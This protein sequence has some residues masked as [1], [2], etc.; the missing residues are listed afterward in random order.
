MK[1]KI[2][3]MT[4]GVPH[5]AR[6]RAY[7][8]GAVITAG[9]CGVA[10]R[11]YALQVDE[12]DHY[13]ELAER[14]HQTDV[15]IPAPRGNV[16]DA[17][18]RPLAVSADADSIWANPREIHD[19]T[20]VADKLGKLVNMEPGALE[21]KL[22]VDKKF[23]WIARQV[24]PEVAVAV[25]N[26]K[27]P[28]IVVAKEPRRWYPGKTIGGPVIGRADIDSRGLEG[29]ELSM[30]DVL[31]GSRGNGQAVRDAHGRKMFA[32]GM[33]Q[34]E[35]GAT[36]QLSLDRSIQATADQAIADAVISHKAKSG[37]VVVVEVATGRVLA[38]SSY[39]TYDPNSN[40]QHNAARNRPVT[41]AFESGSV[42]KVFTVAA[43]IDDGLVGAQTELDVGGGSFVVGPKRITDVHPYKY[44]TVSDIIKHSSNVGA[45]KIGLRLGRDK[46][47]S[48]FKQ[49][50][51]GAKSGIELPGEQVGMMRNGAK[52]RDIELATMSYGYG[53]TVTP[54]QVAAGLAALGNGGVYN[55]PRIIDKV[56]D[57]DGTVLYRPLGESK[58]MVK[59]QT[60]ATMQKILGTVFEGGKDGG[61]AKDVIVPGFKCGGKTGTAYKYDPET[62]HYATDRYL[63]SFAGLAP[64]DNPK[65]AIVVMVDE[66]SGG[67]HYGGDVAGPV[68][69]TVASE[70]LRYLGVPGT[71]P[72]CPP[73][74]PGYN[75]YLDTSVK[76]CL[77]STPPP[78]AP[79]PAPAPA[80]APE[81]APVIDDDPSAVPAPEPGSIAI[82]DFAG[83]GVQRA[84]DLARESHL[85]VDVKGTGRV[86]S[87]D[88][89][90]G[91][92]ATP[93]RI[94]LTFSDGAPG[95]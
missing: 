69:G 19:V 41:D 73:R 75:P 72:V 3:P 30:N 62:K 16:I 87:Q 7:L 27:L 53:L 93:V 13:R 18:G 24:S 38:M 49:F 60:A 94:T 36:V 5:S 57:P 71:S 6:V 46:L 14:Q 51:F 81:A 54:L 74:P 65:L 15:N 76:T 9:L 59:P 37:V 40:E 31:I 68:F 32:D 17:V 23:V 95:R 70:T 90:P 42:M 84:L 67:F 80:A 77:P 61:T 2:K 86:V 85:A 25:K 56:T 33:S 35:P 50:G 39:P 12:A 20:D 63:A 10:W 44:L 89:A 21:A 28:G 82:P 34:P 8:A 29:V 1:S 4:P 52:W 78:K 43:A 88:P 66:P 47:Y 22:G 83:L 26:A 11:A 64:I 45:A 58:Q 55:P 79:A 92:A 48:Y 91:F